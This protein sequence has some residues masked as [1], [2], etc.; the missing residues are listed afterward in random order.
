MENILLSLLVIGCAG[1]EAQAVPSQLWLEDALTLDHAQA[2]EVAIEKAQFD[3]MPRVLTDLPPE[4]V[5]DISN[6]APPR[7][8][9]SA[10]NVRGL[11]LADMKNDVIALAY[12]NNRG[13]GLG[14][15]STGGVALTGG[16][17][18]E[19]GM[20]VNLYYIYGF[21][22]IAEDAARAAGV[23]VTDLPQR[24]VGITIGWK[25]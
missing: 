9:A 24:S 18:T 3:A 6:V 22:E 12:R 25:F 20:R 13:L 11:N 19:G 21:P 17:A 10:T 7:T 4:A 1:A 8:A 5:V 16:Y 23:E 15:A 14:V 2:Q